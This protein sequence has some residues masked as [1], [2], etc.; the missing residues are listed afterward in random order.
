[1][2]NVHIFCW[3]KPNI[4]TWVLCNFVFAW[5][6]NYS[7]NMCP[8]VLGNEFFIWSSSPSIISFSGIPSIWYF[9]FFLNFLICS[10][11]FYLFFLFSMLWQNQGSHKIWPLL[12]VWEPVV[13]NHP[14]VMLSGT[15]IRRERWREIGRKN[16]PRLGLLKRDA[17]LMISH[18]SKCNFFLPYFFWVPSLIL[19]GLLVLPVGNW[20]AKK[21]VVR[22]PKKAP[23]GS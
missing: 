10:P 11:I 14:T 4:F 22:G 9:P 13:A 19:V 20:E 2:V 5:C 18:I 12:S 8:S 7:E 6:K 21:L 23:G 15:G 17:P 3:L 1:M 16:L